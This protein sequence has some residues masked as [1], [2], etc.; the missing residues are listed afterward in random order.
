MGRRDEV[1]TSGGDAQLD[2]V[3]AQIARANENASGF[4]AALVALDEKIHAAEA[5][6]KNARDAADRARFGSWVDGKMA[7]ITE[8]AE[9]F[10]TAS[11]TLCDALAT[12]SSTGAGIAAALGGAA[13]ALESEIGAITRDLERNRDEVLN[14]TRNIPD[15][16]PRPVPPPLAPDIPRTHVY[17][18]KALRWTED[19]EIKVA[20][21]H[22]SVQLP[23]ALAKVAIARNLADNYGAP[24]CVE[25]RKAFPE[26]LWAPPAREAIDLEALAAEADAKAEQQNEAVA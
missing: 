25:M 18:L 8:A 11:K 9:Q 6:F 20:P 21:K 16:K 19:G 3:N 1:L 24:R 7:Q 4:R 17:T 2:Q 22:G 23:A 15:V 5:A 13:T 12:T 26:I 10:Q 14:G